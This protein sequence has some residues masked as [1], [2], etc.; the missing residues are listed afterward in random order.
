MTS[1]A[2]RQ[3]LEDGDIDGLR[4]AWAQLFPA[5]PQPETRHDAE[6]V[7][8]S[9]RTVASSIPFNKRAYSHCWL[10]E[11][12]LPSQ[13]P[14][15]LKPKAERLYPRVVGGVGISVN[16]RSEWMKPAALEVRAA[17]EHAVLE[18]YAD[19]REEPAF[20]RQRMKEVKHRKVRALFGAR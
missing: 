3:L 14:D 4:S 1:A 5:M 17:L 8:H 15:N 19:G 9:A 6:I 18:A 20:I 7:M 16:M 2:F 10:V 12:M 13:L 11:R